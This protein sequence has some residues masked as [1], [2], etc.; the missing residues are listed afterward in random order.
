MKFYI[1]MIPV[2]YNW[3]LENSIKN[4]ILNIRALTSITQE[5][6]IKNS[7]LFIFKFSV[8]QISYSEH[9]CFQNLK[10]FLW[11]KLSVDFYNSKGMIMA[12]NPANQMSW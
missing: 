5:S 1:R 8:S 9:V 11:E 7:Y 12:R 4:T 2:L 6:R 3:C 10:K